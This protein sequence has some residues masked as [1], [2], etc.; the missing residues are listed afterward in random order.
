MGVTLASLAVSLFVVLS[1][2]VGM[3][4]VDGDGVK[5]IAVVAVHPKKLWRMHV[6]VWCAVKLLRAVLTKVASVVLEIT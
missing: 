5:R 4:V 3:V 1:A 6:L 2:I